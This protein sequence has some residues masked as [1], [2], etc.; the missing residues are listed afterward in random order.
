MIP[1]V[2][3]LPVIDRGDMRI[4]DFFRSDVI[5][6]KTITLARA[7]DAMPSGEA[8]PVFFERVDHHVVI[9]HTRRVRI[10]DGKGDPF[11]R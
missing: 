5:D 7:M 8:E 9:R 11:I 6:A 2:S 3:D 1:P 10:A 4:L